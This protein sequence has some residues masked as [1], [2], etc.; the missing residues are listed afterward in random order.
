MGPM[1]G[2]RSRRCWETGQIRGNWVLSTVFARAGSKN[3]TP[4]WRHNVSFV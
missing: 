2:R 3:D 4:W 1:R